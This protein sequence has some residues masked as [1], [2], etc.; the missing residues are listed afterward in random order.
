MQQAVQVGK[1]SGQAA[2]QGL[3]VFFG[4]GGQ[5]QFNEAGAGSAGCFDLVI[6]RFKLAACAAQQNNGG[7]VPGVG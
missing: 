6:H 7:A 2:G 3:V 1:L 4:R 5:V